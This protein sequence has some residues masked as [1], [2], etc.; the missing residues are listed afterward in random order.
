MRLQGSKMCL[1][2]LFVGFVLSNF[3]LLWD[4]AG[5]ACV[6]ENRQVSACS[7][8]DTHDVSSI[9]KPVFQSSIS[10][11]ASWSFHPRV[12]GAETDFSRLELFN[13]TECH[14]PTNEGSFCCGKIDDSRLKQNRENFSLFLEGNV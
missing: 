2:M 13:A 10:S 3:R 8:H 12:R 14:L 5:S 1:F 4:V 11:R 7:Q 6:D 9:S